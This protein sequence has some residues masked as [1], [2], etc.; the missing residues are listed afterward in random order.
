VHSL[1]PQSNKRNSI[2]NF[3][4]KTASMADDQS[5]SPEVGQTGM[6]LLRILKY[7]TL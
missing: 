3:L 6:N 7:K 2:L 1:V 5:L 4:V